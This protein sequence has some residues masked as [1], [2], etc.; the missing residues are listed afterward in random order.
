VNTTHFLQEHLYPL[1]TGL[2]DLG[3]SVF[4]W[5][6]IWTKNIDISGTGTITTTP[7]AGTDIANK[8]YVDTAAS[9]KPTVDEAD[10]NPS[11]ANVT[12]ITFDQT[13]G[14]VVSNP[15]GT[16]ARID[17]AAI[18]S[19]AIADLAA[20]K[21][22]GQVAAANGGTGI[23]TSGSTG[24]ATV[25]AGTWSILAQLTAALGGTGINTGASTGVPSIS[26]GTW[27]VAAT[28]T[29]ALGGTNIASYTAGDMITATGATTLAK[30]AKGNANDVIGMNNANT[31][32]EYKA[33]AAGT[34][35][36]VV[37][38]ANTVTIN[39]TATAG[40]TIGL[41]I[42]LPYPTLYL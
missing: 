42:A 20:S 3:N 33:I 16:Q 2:V 27:S 35:I 21:L 36:S 40:V 38:T 17:L 28:L 6:T 23:D 4:R 31:T 41:A 5:R 25:A 7:A 1:V 8:T 22:T 18:P 29:V 15:A 13:D 24:V 10:G 30:L 19:A 14:F 34:N 12:Q 32:Q 9:G 11:I 39:N 26:A 37:H